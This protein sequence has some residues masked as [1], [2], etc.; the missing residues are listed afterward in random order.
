MCLKYNFNKENLS[1]CTAITQ[2]RVPCCMRQE[3]Q[4]VN[5]N[6]IYITFTHLADHLFKAAQEMNEENNKAIYQILEY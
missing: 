5:I 1:F 4:H 3:R 6:D 2:Q